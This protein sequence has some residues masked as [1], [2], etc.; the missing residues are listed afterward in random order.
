MSAISPKESVKKSE[1]LSG[2]LRSLSTEWETIILKLSKLELPGDRTSISLQEMTITFYIQSEEQP[3]LSGLDY[4][5][6]HKG[7]TLW[8]ERNKQSIEQEK[9]RNSAAVPLFVNAVIGSGIAH[10]LKNLFSLGPASPQLSC[11]GLPFSS[12]YYLAC[13]AETAGYFGKNGGLCQL[14]AP[15][16]SLALTLVGPLLLSRAAMLA[17]FS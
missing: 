7:E 5:N 1:S 11:S 2:G 8:T 4:N 12:C 13:L 16:T 6:V 17:G 9:P 15:E 3:V 14:K 10:S